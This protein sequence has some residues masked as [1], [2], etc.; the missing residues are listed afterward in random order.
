MVL[1]A[2]TLLSKVLLV[3]REMAMAAVF[4][5]SSMSDAY[6]TATSILSLVSVASLASLVVAYIPIISG[7]D[8]DTQTYITNNFMTVLSGLTLLLS[9]LALFF[10]REIVVLFASGFSDETVRQT[11]L[12]L[13]IT[14]PLLFF[15]VILNITVA[16]LQYK[17]SFWYQGA[18]AVLTD[19]IVVVSVLLSRR[20][21]VVLAAGYT[22]SI[23]LPALLGLCLARRRGLRVRPECSVK[24][25]YLRELLVLSIPIFI[26]QIMIQLNI[27]IDKNFA[28]RLGTGI[29]TNLNYA[30]RISDVLVGTIV[31]SV[32]TVLYPRM[33]RQAAEGGAG[34]SNTLEQGLRTASLIAFPMAAGTMLLSQPIVNLLLLRGNYSV[35]AAFVTSQSLFYYAMGMLPLGLIYILN[36]AFFAMKDTKTPVFTGAFAIALNIVLNFVLVRVLAYRGLAIATSAANYLNLVLYLIWMRKRAGDEWIQGFVSSFCKIAAATGIMVA[37]VIG[38]RLLLAG[39][40]PVG[41]VGVLLNCVVLAAVGA[42]IYVVACVLLREKS[43]VEVLNAVRRRR[44]E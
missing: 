28:S 31:P 11:Q 17:G 43:V 14:L 33:S 22:L 13:R 7:K 40:L 4:G 9:V 32:A 37:G 41:A 8:E 24:N 25:R 18:S 36:N 12:V 15:N 5:A 6:V 34:F 27:I 21:L 10:T 16:Y 30:H 38:M 23:V 44:S 20:E 1:I 42:A 3:F 26:S 19:G 39:Q 2:F 35:E 29:V